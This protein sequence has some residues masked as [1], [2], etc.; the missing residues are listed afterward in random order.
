MA[1]PNP[2]TDQLSPWKMIGE[3]PVVK[4]IG[5]RVPE[6]DYYNFMEIPKDIRVEM[7]RNFVKTE[8]DKYK[9]IKEFSKR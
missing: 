9:K 4:N 6:E 7:L 2:R 8:G 5:I 1:N 3:K